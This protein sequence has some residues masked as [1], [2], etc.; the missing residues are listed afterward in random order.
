MTEVNQWR[1]DCKFRV[2]SPHLNCTV[3]TTGPCQGC[4]DFEPI[5]R[6]DQPEMIVRLP[7]GRTFSIGNENDYCAEEIRPISFS[8]LGEEQVI[9]RSG[10]RRGI[11]FPER[12]NQPTKFQ[13]TLLFLKARSQTLWRVWSFAAAIALPLIAIGVD[14]DAALLFGVALYLNC[15]VF[16]S[17]KHL[18]MYWLL[19]LNREDFFVSIVGILFLMMFRV[20][21]NGLLGQ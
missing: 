13:R 8:D 6:K 19:Y 12:Y 11:P 17:I 10:Q 21:R 15:L 18:D 2:H 14:F 20:F 16:G 4:T 1:S 9:L 5:G 3:H 7:D